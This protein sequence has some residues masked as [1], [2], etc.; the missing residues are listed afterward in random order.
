MKILLIEDDKFI[1]NFYVSKLQEN[2]YEVDSAS[3]GSE[4]LEKINK[5]HYDLILLDLVM[6][7]L[8]GFEVLKTLNSDE[9]LKKIPVLVLSSLGQEQDV[10]KA[11]Q[12]GAKDYINKTFFNFDEL[13]KRIQTLTT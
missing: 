8:D 7:K 12:L 11:K 13:I 4:G 9:V 1:Q 6:P 3:N 10:E 2:K 5:N